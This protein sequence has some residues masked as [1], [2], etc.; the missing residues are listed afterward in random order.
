MKKKGTA[1]GKATAHAGIVTVADPVGVSIRCLDSVV[2]E[3]GPIS[4][5]WESEVTLGYNGVLMI[6]TGC[7]LD[8]PINQPKKQGDS[9][10]ARHYPAGGLPKHD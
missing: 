5:W 10:T 7:I 2:S 4:F 8:R 1:Q 9:F 3:T 6:P